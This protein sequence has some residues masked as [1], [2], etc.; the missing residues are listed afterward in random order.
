MTADSYNLVLK[1][2]E[3]CWYKA[4][5]QVNKH[6]ALAHFFERILLLDDTDSF[7]PNAP[8]RMDAID[9][10]LKTSE[11]AEK[12]VEAL[13]PG[14]QK[15]RCGHQVRQLVLALKHMRAGGRIYDSKAEARAMEDYKAGRFVTLDELMKRLRE[16][17][18]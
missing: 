15:E 9:M 16:R 5:E 8:S 3:R 11:D 7:D 12:H 2:A 4:P 13:S 6:N 10:A 18:E 17:S 1:D 14:D